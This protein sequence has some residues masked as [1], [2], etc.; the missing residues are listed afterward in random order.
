MMNFLKDA[1]YLLSTLRAS[2]PNLFYRCSKRSYL[3]GEKRLLAQARRTGSV[4]EFGVEIKKFLHRIH[5]GH[6][7]LKT[8]PAAFQ[9][10]LPFDSVLVE[11][12][13]FIKTVLPA[14]CPVPAKAEILAVNNVPARAYLELL[15]GL[16]SYELRGR[17]LHIAARRLPYSGTHLAGSD[18]ITLLVRGLDGEKQLLR[19]EWKNM[20]AWRPSPAV[21]PF[22]FRYL[23]NIGAGY[24]DWRSFIDTRTYDFYCAAGAVKRNAAERKRLPDWEGSL[25]EIFGELAGKKAGSLIVDLR[26]NTGGNS[27]LGENLIEY[28]TAE[29]VRDFSGYVRLSPLLKEHYSGIYGRLFD[30]F[31]MGARVTNKQLEAAIGANTF[32]KTFALKKSPA[33]K[34]QGR[35]FLL[36][37]WVTYSAAE[38]FAALIKDNSL[39][40]LLGEPAGNGANGPI[41]SLSFTLP[42]SKLE[43][44]A[45]FAFRFRPDPGR[46]RARLLKPD[47]CV[48]QTIKD[49]YAGKDTVLEYAKKL[50]KEVQANRRRPPPADSDA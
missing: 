14:V 22:E 23:K 24:L 28:L 5:D 29:S 41:D 32:S 21:S 12:R 9:H 42:G 25:K 47:I 50:C 48:K 15:T 39:G 16:M 7:C 37:G 30:L 10:K 3:E 35:V 33:N 13:L 1:E 40:V 49:F 31:P 46:R 11:G 18:V 27:A 45:S 34:F 4:A 17:A 26:S 2:H 44:G 36:I 8:Q 43:I 20:Q 38:T 19:F 6:T